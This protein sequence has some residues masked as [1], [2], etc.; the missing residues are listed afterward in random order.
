VNAP[1]TS[2]EQAGE[3]QDEETTD[4]EWLPSNSHT[5]S[6]PEFSSLADFGVPF[7]ES[8]RSQP[9]A[10][11]LFKH[12]TGVVAKQL[13]WYDHDANPW[14]NL[15]APLALN[16][17]TLFTAILAMSSGNILSRMDNSHVG[18]SPQFQSMQLYREN[19]LKLLSK[20]IRDLRSLPATPWSSTHWQSA[21]ATLASVIILSYLD[22]HF[23]AS[24]VWR[25][26]LSGA[27]Q[28]VRAVQKPPSGDPTM[29]FL[30]EEV[31]AATTWPL[32]TDY[33]LDMTTSRETVELQDLLGTVT[34]SDQESGFSGFCLALRRIT[35]M[36]RL[37]HQSASDGTLYVDVESASE[38]ITQILVE[39]RSSALMTVTP[40]RLQNSKF[41]GQDAKHLID[42]YFHATAA[43]KLRALRLTAAEGRTLDFHRSQLLQ[44]LLAFQDLE[45]FAQDQTWPLF[46]AGTE[47]KDAVDSQEWIRGRFER[48]MRCSCALDRPRVLQFLEEFWRQSDHE[49]WIDYGR[50]RAGDLAN[51]L[52]L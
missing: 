30:A 48:I 4:A 32:L 23:P 14:R 49:S 17:Q 34:M 45:S 10:V 22:V 40:E 42:A 39:A 7:V 44:S 24:G 50:H 28:V 26:H 9:E 43:Y 21:K 33:S 41:E 20:D 27:Q 12:F 51:F 29:S 3:G 47:S 25:L 5:T 1:T 13:A 6:G 37:C 46:V 2:R 18:T 35:L 15:I 31:F 36:E 8:L 11:A 52:I 16:S 38:K 19:A